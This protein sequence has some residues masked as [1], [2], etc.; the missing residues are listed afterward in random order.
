VCLGV[1]VVSLFGAN[2]AQADPRLT[3]G[4][5]VAFTA[6][7]VSGEQEY[8]PRFGVGGGVY[9]QGNAWKTIDLR[10]EANYVP[11]GARLAFGESQVEWQMDYIEIPILLVV[12]L[13]PKSRT[14]VELFAGVAYGI[15]LNRQ[16][17]VGDDVG[18]ELDDYVKYWDSD[19]K[20]YVQ[21][22]IDI[23][24][25]TT[26]AMESAEKSDVGFALGMALNVPTGP[27]NFLVDVRY[28]S[29]LTD[30]VVSGT[31]TIQSGEGAQATYETA[32]VDFANRCFS[33]SVGFAFPFGARSAPEPE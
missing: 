31:Y 18:Y 9:L 21:P 10:V 25:T 12:N 11:K 14:S 17:E 29:G 28:V 15:G 26:L 4:V 23:N 2:L 33:F 22:V 27:V 16:I 8:D 32:P 20:A 7:D 5:R 24:P 30:P 13:S 3:G 6:S 1:A 19:L